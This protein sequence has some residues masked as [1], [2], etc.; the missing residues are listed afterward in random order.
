MAE[1]LQR[2]QNIVPRS[3]AAR[4]AASHNRPR[5]TGNIIA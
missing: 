3:G 2:Q 5:K 1:A 4:H